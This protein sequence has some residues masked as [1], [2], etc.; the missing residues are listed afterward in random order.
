MVVDEKGEN[1]GNTPIIIAKYLAITQYC[2]AVPRKYVAKRVE[3]PTEL[4][5][6]PLHRQDCALT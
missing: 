1:S 2:E 5:R 4:D 6:Y 3:P